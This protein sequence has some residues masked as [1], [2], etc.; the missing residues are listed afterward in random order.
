[1][2]WILLLVEV[3]AGTLVY[4]LTFH[5]FQERWKCFAYSHRLS[6]RLMALVWNF[7]ARWTVGS[8]ATCTRRQSQNSLETALSSNQ[9]AGKLGGSLSSL[10]SFIKGRLGESLISNLPDGEEYGVQMWL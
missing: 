9:R 2:M 7:M 4:G 3:V 8:L 10:A 6:D 5:Y 1:M